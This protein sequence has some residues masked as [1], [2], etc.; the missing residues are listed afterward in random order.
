MTQIK[1][2]KRTRAQGNDL[3]QTNYCAQ[4]QADRK[5]KMLEKEKHYDDLSIKAHTLLNKI[6]NDAKKSQTKELTNKLT[7]AESLNQRLFDGKNLT[8][9]QLW[10]LNKLLKE[11]GV[12]P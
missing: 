4:T 8:D 2:R 7:I 12:Q 1:L 9:K 11:Y 6:Q 10:Q 3:N 5:A